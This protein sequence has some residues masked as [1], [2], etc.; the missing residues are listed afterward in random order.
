MRGGIWDFQQVAAVHALATCVRVLN[1]RPRNGELWES[2]I[3][4]NPCQPLLGHLPLLGH[5]YWG[6]PERS[7]ALRG[8]SE[9][10]GLHFG[11]L[12]SA[13]TFGGVPP[14]PL[15]PPT[16]ISS[17]Q[18]LKCR[19]PVKTIASPS[20]SAAAITSSSRTEPPGWITA[21]APASATASSPSGKGKN[22]SDAATQPPS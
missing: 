10:K 5:C 3:T 1:A 8:Q 9:S 6:H 14:I 21:V 22:A 17:A 20:L 12:S 11:V 15:T 7:L 13:S 19:I 18:C 2:A 16:P 4:Q